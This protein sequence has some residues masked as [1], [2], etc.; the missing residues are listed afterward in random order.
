[1]TTLYEL[2]AGE[3]N[4]PALLAPGKPP[5]TYG[6]LRENV[7]KLAAQLNQFGF[8][9]GD[10][11]AIAMI[12]GPE[13]I[14]A[15]LA[16]ATAGTSAPLNPKYKQEEFAFYYE[17][18]AAKAL[19]T[20]PEGIPAA[21]AAALPTMT[22]LT[23][24]ADAQGRCSLERAA[25]QAR[26]ATYAPKPV[27]LS[28]EDD[29]AMILHTSG[30]TSRPK[31]VPLRHRNLFASAGNIRGTYS[32]SSADITLC[33]MPLFHIHGI[34]GSML[35]T[36]SS[37][38]TVVCP[39]GFNA[40]EF[41]SLFE[42]YSPTWYSAVPT[43]HQ[44]VLARLSK[45]A[46]VVRKKPLRFIRSSSAPMPGVV[47]ERLEELFQA[48]QLDSY[49]MTEASHQMASNPLPPRER[50]GGS[51][52]IGFGV[53]VRI[54][55]DVGNLLKPGEIGEVVVRGPNVVDGY[56]N[57]PEANAAAYTNGWFRTGD[58]GVQDAEG[59][60]SLTGRI[61]ELINRGGE[62]VSPLEIDDVLLRHPAV[63]EALA[64]AVP[65]KMLGEE[66][67]AA[68]VLKGEC[69]SAELRAHCAAALAEYKVPKKFHVLTEI[70]RGATGKLQRINMA[71]FLQVGS[72]D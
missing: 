39:A 46:D 4:H 23:V 48:P 22:L 27:E 8:G 58:Q 13:L 56:E 16:A 57:N 66:I 42:T 43:M 53:E 28:L 62:K 19:I 1:M 36:L 31:R 55:D 20:S 45:H 40:M 17:D 68:V 34:V 59:Y 69:E 54:M 72:E 44:M 64:F 24:E 32:L 65:H 35:S 29:V 50:K 51:V 30:T 61:K 63:A 18:T 12:N 60:L 70:P 67:H 11:I 6:Q 25:G 41:L 49:G 2:L 15:F 33:V 5:V 7:L 9:R 26:S 3:D 21:I 47:R 52:G 10:R 38:G 14:T 71:K 37:G